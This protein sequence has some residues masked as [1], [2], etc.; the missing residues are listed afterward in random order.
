MSRAIDH[1]SKWGAPARIA[2]DGNGSNRLGAAT[3]V[4]GVGGGE[5]DIFISKVNEKRS[6]FIRALT[7][8]L[9]ELKET[10]EIW[11]GKKSSLSNENI[12]NTPATAYLATLHHLRD[13]CH[14]T[15][16]VDVLAMLA[17]CSGGS[18]EFDSSEGNS[19]VSSLHNG[20]PT[21]SYPEAISLRW[22]RYATP[23]VEG[24]L[25]SAYEDYLIV[26]IKT[27]ELLIS[28]LG[29]LFESAAD[30]T[31]C[32]ISDLDPVD[33]IEVKE[34]ETENEASHQKRNLEE[35]IEGLDLADNNDESKQAHYER[36]KFAHTL[37]VGVVE[38]V[39]ITIPLLSA[40][41]SAGAM[42]SPS[43][44]ALSSTQK[45]AGKVARKLQTLHASVVH[46]TTEAA[47]RYSG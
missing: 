4:G 31:L 13:N 43:N 26:A 6:I 38:A 34:E 16:A 37:A 7:S 41:G 45:N 14:E 22:A 19:E 2:S 39:R 40:L 21:W 20:F 18:L 5:D 11:Q 9:A 25:F 10:S 3:G 12:K 27:S 47:S 29:P 24:L 35:A 42:S 36:R 23:V 44:G 33:D 28:A 30:A 17:H 32:T 15:C 46:I 1:N 8:R